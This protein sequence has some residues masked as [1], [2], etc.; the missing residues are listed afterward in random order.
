MSRFL[1]PVLLLATGLAAQDAPT[2]RWR[3]TLTISDETDP[4]AAELGKV[5]GLAT[6][7]TGNIYA[8][9][10]DNGFIVVFGPDGR[11]RGQVGR[12]GR[13]PGEFQ[14]PSGIVIDAQQRLWVRDTERI[15]RFSRDS[16]TGLLARYDTAYQQPLYADWYNARASRMHTSGDYLHTAPS[17]A[18]GAQKRVLRYGARG[19]VTDSLMVPRWPNET[20][21]YARFQVSANTGRML[22]G[23]DV[24]PF[25]AVP[26][27]DVTPRGT[28]LSTGGDRYEIRESD[29]SGR[30]VRTITHAAAV[31]PIV[32]AE[33][34]ESLAAMNRRLDSI[35]VP[36]NKVEG[37]SDDVRARRLPTHYPPIQSLFAAPDGTT[38]VR[39]WAGAGQRGTSVF[40][41][42]DANGRLVRTVILPAVVLDAP[43]PV[44]GARL[45]VAAVEDRETGGVRLMR[46]EP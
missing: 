23:L 13:G 12:K 19:Q 41:V 4:R 46:F 39:R 35:P 34:A 43:T 8:A 21:G 10:I 22:R 24:P 31:V 14:A 27:W 11:F 7:G 3:T 40:D 15:T 30:T 6:D 20:T 26:A 5:F 16:R 29:A 42:F 37:M 18:V 44:L 9:D 32:A 28:I 38:W 33:R 36:L 25:T 1:L 45:I 2:A 17:A